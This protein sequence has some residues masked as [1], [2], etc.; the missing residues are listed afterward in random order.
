MATGGSG[1]TLTGIIG[2]LVAQAVSS[3]S[4]VPLEQVTALGAYL[5]GLAGDIAAQAVGR[6]SLTAGDLIDY[7]PKAIRQLEGE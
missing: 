1:D 4:S 2:S 7:L 3:G 5:H 6:A